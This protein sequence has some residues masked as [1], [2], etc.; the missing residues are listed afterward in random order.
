[1]SGEVI[2]GNRELHVLVSES[3]KLKGQVGTVALNAARAELGNCE[4]C[5]ANAE[6]NCANL[7]LQ[8]QTLTDQNMQLSVTINDL[9]AQLNASRAECSS[10]QAALANAEATIANLSN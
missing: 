10:L 3:L 9:T 5:L 7:S 1:L 8:L 6:S 4:A 2:N